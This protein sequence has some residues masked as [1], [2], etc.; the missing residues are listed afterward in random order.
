M[1]TG[2]TAQSVKAEEEEALYMLKVLVPFQT[3][4]AILV[5]KLLNVIDE[6]DS[7]TL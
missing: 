5:S 2:Q 1:G 3:S 4:G 6:N 7:K